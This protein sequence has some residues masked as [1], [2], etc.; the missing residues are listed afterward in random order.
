MTY[1]QPV[2]TCETCGKQCYTTKALAKK[3]VRQMRGRQ[4]RLNVYRCGAAWHFGHPPAVL[5]AGL[6]ARDEI[7]VRERK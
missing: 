1:A 7:R 4:G 5:V 6:I 3:A 2:G